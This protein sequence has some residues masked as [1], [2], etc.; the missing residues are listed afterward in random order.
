MNSLEITLRFGQPGY[1]ADPYHAERFKLIEIQKQSGMMRT[2]SEANRRRALEDHLRA[3]GMTLADYQ[4]LE[5]AASRPFFTAPTPSPPPSPTPPSTP[6]PTIII[7]SDRLLSCLV[8]ANDVAPARR[9]IP[10]L[11]CA[12]RATDFVTNRHEPDGVWERFAVVTGAQGKLSNQ[13]AMRRNA[14]IRDFTATGTL[15]HDPEM[16]KP[17]TILELLRFAGLNV[18]IGASRKMGWGRFEVTA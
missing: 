10:N 5:R 2:R 7:P 9:R 3:N 11:R 8:N 18:G 17:D 16:V 12:I 6:T 15:S 13:R 1:I 14:F 4:E